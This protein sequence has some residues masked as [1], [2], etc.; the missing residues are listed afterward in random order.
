VSIIS[1]LLAAVVG[2]T[3]LWT[4]AIKALAPHTFRR[5]LHSLGWLPERRLADAV[6]I[7]AAAE[8]AWGIALITG[9][10]RGV[11]IPF[12][13]FMFLLLS[14]ASWW[15]VRSGKTP[16]CGCYGGFIQPSIIQSVGLNAVYS[17]LLLVSVAVDSASAPVSV[18]RIVVVVASAV[19]FG[20]TAWWA[21]RFEWK[22]GRLLLD[23]SPLKE[24]ARWRHNWAGGLTSGMDGEVLVSLLGPDCPFCKDWVN[25]GNAVSRSSELPRMIGVVAAPDDKVRQFIEQNRTRFPVASISP[26][27][28]ARLTRTV[29]TT[30]LIEGNQIKR[31]WSGSMPIEFYDRFRR[32]FFPDVTSA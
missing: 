30:A 20:T 2:A 7:A 23:T 8:G 12:S 13:V 17:I 1:F 18:M 16:D 26:S 5:H 29:P 15:G 9:F 11:V 22:T 28:M 25:V 3:L 27:L 14:A 21:Q 31:V 19:I 10:A 6:T 32:A 24:G 4:A